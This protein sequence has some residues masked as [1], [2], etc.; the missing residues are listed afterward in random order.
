MNNKTI[1]SLRHSP[2]HPALVLAS[3]LVSPMVW[4]QVSS[5]E[6][7]ATAPADSAKPAK[8]LPTVAVTANGDSAAEAPTEST[9]SYTVR[10]ANA[11]TGLNLSPRET[12]QAESVVT[13]A[14]MDDFRL[15]TANDV[16]QNATGVTVERIETDR[17]YYTAR[18]FDIT[19]FQLDGVTQTMAAGN[20]HGDLDTI[21]YDRVEVLRG[22][23]GLLSGTGNPSATVNYVRKRPTTDNRAALGLSYG[24]WDDRRL[25]ADVSG[26]LNQ[27]RTLR[28]RFVAA[29]EDKE[30]YLDRYRSNRTVL[31]ATLE[32]DISDNTTLAAGMSYQRNAPKG[33]M[34]G[35]LPMYYSNGRQTS[36]ARSTSTATDWTKW[37]VETRT[38]FADLV[39]H[40]SDDWQTRL[41][42][43]S[44]DLKER[45][46]LFYVYGTPEESSGSGLASYPSRYDMDSNQS[47]ID[48]RTN[49]AFSLAGKR[50]EVVFGTLYSRS[51]VKDASAYGEG[52]GT[53]IPDLTSW[54]GNYA[55]PLFDASYDGGA[56][57]DTQR[58][59][60]A[61]TRLHLAERWKLIAGATNTRMFSSGGDYGVSYAR[62]DS[63]TT[64]YAGLLYDLSANWTAYTSYAQIFNPQYQLTPELQRLAPAK[65]DTKEIGLKGELL[66]KRLSVNAAL[67]NTHQR[68]LATDA[69]Y[70]GTTQVYVGQNVRSQ[71]YELDLAG[72][73]T[74]AVKISAGLTGLT[75]KDQDGNEARTF[76]PRHAWHLSTTWQPLQALTLG[77]Q[78]RWQGDIHRDESDTIITRQKA[79]ALLD[80]MA[81]YDINKHWSAKLNVNNVTNKKYIN[82]LYWSQ[83]YYGAP[84]NGSVALN[85]TY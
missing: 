34:W 70:V 28:G 67:F 63:T 51:R 64:P 61:A 53:A 7:P 10:R 65:G 75:L 21:L 48:L 39:H 62:E 42:V 9:R 30:S 19:N 58:S 54:Y 59:V 52:I 68:N 66:D 76:T 12:P 38:G 16:L 29:Y 74:A 2:L 14:Q 27:A 80:V 50:H 43:S 13:R 83:A 49:G 82:S 79:Y 11:A 23:N 73:L 18:G 8:T 71:G 77:A 40:Y 44:T 78:L 33:T 3:I 60:Y 32:G 20:V 37:I 5:P 55:E 4:G 25:E 17:T 35:A 85:W 15:N 46:V 56:Y 1:R 6:K 57:Q 31:G 45:G 81:K 69:G 26:P 84:V 22:A 24:S 41:S 47:Q 72:A 36:Y